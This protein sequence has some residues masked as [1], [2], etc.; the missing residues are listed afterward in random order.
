MLVVGHHFGDCMV[1][2]N[3]LHKIRMCI[4]LLSLVHHF[5][6]FNFIKYASVLDMR[7]ILVIFLASDCDTNSIHSFILYMN[8]E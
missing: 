6:L 3:L 2:R 8:G 4:F 7:Q 5:V 1:L